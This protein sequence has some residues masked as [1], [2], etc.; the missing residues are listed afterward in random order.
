M[1]QLTQSIG[2]SLVITC[3]FTFGAKV[4]GQNL[5]GTI[6]DSSGPVVGARVTFFN[7]DTSYFREGRSD[8]AGGYSFAAVAA[9]NYTLGASYTGKEYRQVSLALSSDTVVNFS[10]STE[11]QTGQWNVI[12]QSPEPLGG[13]DLAI[14][15]PNGKIFYCHNTLDPFV[16]DPEANGTM[17]VQGDNTLQG[18]AASLLLP[19]G[20]VVFAG[21]T[22]VEVYGPGIRKVKTY[23]YLTNT[24]Q[25]KP[26]MI[27]YRW[28]PTMTRLADGKLLIT[29][30]GTQANPQRTNSTELYDPSTGTSQ[31]VDSTAIPQEISPIVMLN[32]G[33]ILMTFRPP[34][35]YTPA[36]QQWNAC[37]DFLQGNRNPDGDHA[38]HELVHL[39]EGTVVAVGYKSY[40]AGVPGNLI[41]KYDPTS[42]SWSYGAN[43]A[44]VRSRAKTVLLPGKN[45]LVLAG[46]KEDPANSTPTNQWGYMNIAD[47]YNPYTEQWRRLAAM[48]YFREYHSLPVLVPDGRVIIVGGEGEP[49]NEPPFS[50]IE[51]FSPPYLFRGIRPQIVNFSQNIFQRGSQIV[52]DVI[53]TDS[54]TSVILMSTPS[55]THF[56]NSGNNRYVELPFTKTGNTI[57]ATIP[58]DSL[59]VL[60]GYY[61]L[62]AMVDDIPSAGKMIK[63]QSTA[64]STTA[65]VAVT[66]GWNL[67]SVPVGVS[68]FRKSTLF[69]QAVSD[70]FAYTGDYEVADTLENGRGF[71]LKFSSAQEISLVGNSLMSDTIDV[72][73]EWNMIGTISSPIAVSTIVQE[74]SGIV[75]SS[76]FGYQNGYVASDTLLP[77]K[78]Y[79]V[80]VNAAGKLIL[81]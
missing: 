4:I 63:V 50:V 27:G 34:Q 8:A 28:Y 23:D 2:I 36:T 10:L 1:R 25:P 3:L 7:S 15:L 72:M 57:T 17:L 33:N 18:C 19:D 81:R 60:D 49:G 80:K 65:T 69:P 53:R 73:Q 75:E 6:A 32:N 13:T 24:W 71:W 79:W 46:Y 52:F 62:F 14:L 11:T 43:F 45:I 41:E 68:D 31:G 56:M 12:V 21:G 16:F 54:V 37:S 40:T 26:D 38:D 77:G 48:N 66:S 67:I 39:P 51:A 5:S 20:K 70:A 78:G 74:P 30:G 61:Q 35:L 58:S 59:N 22:N 55:I 42:N 64:S 76:Y 47:I 44:P 9:G 29:G